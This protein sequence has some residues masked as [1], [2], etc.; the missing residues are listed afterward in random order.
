MVKEL[1]IKEKM[2][3]IVTEVNVKEAKAKI[4]EALGSKKERTLE[5]IV[6]GYVAEDYKGTMYK[7]YSYLANTTYYMSFDPL[8]LFEKPKAKRGEES[9][10]YCS[11]KIRQLSDI[12]II[13]NGVAI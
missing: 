9:P 4:E 6:T 7:Y 11:L 8:N 1:K 13:F 10:G 5:L 2:E 3:T 12:E